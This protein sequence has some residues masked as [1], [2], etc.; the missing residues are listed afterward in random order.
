MC[1]IAKN[2]YYNVF[3]WIGFIALIAFFIAFALILSKSSYIYC[4]NR[5]YCNDQEIPI[6]TSNDVC[7]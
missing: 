2:A 4:P 3:S 5:N 1:Y 7:T 6:L